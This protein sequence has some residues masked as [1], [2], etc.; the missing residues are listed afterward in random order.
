MNMKHEE[1]P[2]DEEIQIAGIT[3]SG[4]DGS[5]PGEAIV[6]GGARSRAEGIRA[7]KR[8]IA[9]RFGEE[10]SD[11]RLQSQSLFVEDAR[12]VDRLTIEDASGDTETL[13]FEV[14]DFFRSGD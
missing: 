2:A 6:I 14:S 9:R 12:A 7:E 10:G 11:W 8:Y 4:G 13:Y 1:D 3:Y 5:A